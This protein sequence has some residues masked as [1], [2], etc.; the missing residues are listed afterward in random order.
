MGLIIIKSMKL[1]ILAVLAAISSTQAHAL[2]YFELETYG[3][4]TESEGEI[5][6]KNTF[7]TGKQADLSGDGSILRN[8]FEVEYGLTDRWTFGFYGDFDKLTGKDWSYR[9]F[10]AKAHT[11]FAEQSELLF[12]FGAYAEL[13]FWNKQGH[14]TEIEVKAIIEKAW[15]HFAFTLNPGFEYKIVGEGKKEIEP[16]YSFALTSHHLTAFETRIDHFAD[17]KD[18]KYL[19]GAGVE[20][21][22][23]NVFDLDVAYRTGLNK[24]SERHLISFAVQAEF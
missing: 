14:P 15:N 4:H 6:L 13:E 3:Y 1:P 18:D 8:T 22:L 16:L 11:R 23:S 5:E 12:D 10:R 19:I 20:Y 24:R 7:T 17:L 9:G 2:N 21:S